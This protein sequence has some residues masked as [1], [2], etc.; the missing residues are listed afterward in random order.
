MLV[1]GQQPNGAAAHVSGVGATDGID[2]IELGATVGSSVNTV[3]LTG[4]A[5]CLGARVEGLV[6]LVVGARVDG[7][8][9]ATANGAGVAAGNG[10]GVAAGYGAGVAASDGAGVAAAIGGGV[11]VCECGA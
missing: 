2:G 10:A 4:V 5:I 8:G 7:T 11:G 9:I 3:A 1:P 6:G